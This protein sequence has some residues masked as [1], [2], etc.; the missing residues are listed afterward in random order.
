MEVRHI[1]VGEKDLPTPSQQAD[2]EQWRRYF[3]VFFVFAEQYLEHVCVFVMAVLHHHR[4]VSG[5][6]VGDAVLALT[7]HCL[8]Q[9]NTTKASVR[10]GFLLI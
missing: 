5:Q 4:L 7:V 8:S 2:T 3:R 1:K 10:E 6:R 9:H